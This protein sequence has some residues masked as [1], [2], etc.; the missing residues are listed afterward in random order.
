MEGY[1]ATK[2]DEILGLSAKGLTAAVVL[3]IGYRSDEDKTQ[4]GK[5]VRKPLTDLFEVV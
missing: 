4:H 3:P 5:K 2:Y 1:D